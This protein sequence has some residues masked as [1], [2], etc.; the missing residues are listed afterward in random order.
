MTKTWFGGNFCPN[1]ATCSLED[2]ALSPSNGPKIRTLD[3]T[4]PRETPYLST[5]QNFPDR[6]SFNNANT[7]PDEWAKCEGQLMSIAQNS[8]LFS[9]LGTQYGGDGRTTFGIPD[10]KTTGNGDYY[11]YLIANLRD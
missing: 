3:L 9:L 11:I 10:L 8:E 2:G 7:N 1:G 6:L 5:V 4:E